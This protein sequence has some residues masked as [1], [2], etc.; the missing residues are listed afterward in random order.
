MKQ[1]SA[2]M[3]ELN[4]CTR[5]FMHLKIYANLFSGGCHD[6]FAPKKPAL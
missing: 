2:R 4:F 5:A 3:A 1:R 6:V